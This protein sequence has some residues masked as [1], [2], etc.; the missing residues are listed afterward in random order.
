MQF[1]TRFSLALLVALVATPSAAHVGAPE[2]RGLFLDDDGSL[3]GA[4]TT[5]GVIEN[6][7]EG[8]VRTCEEA[9]GDTVHFYYWAKEREE[10]IVGTNGGILT[11]SDWGC[12]WDPSGLEDRAVTL[13]RTPRDQPGVLFASTSTTGDANGVFRSIDDGAT[14]AATSLSL[15]EFAFTSLQ[16]SVDGQLV[17]A[18]GIDYAVTLPRIFLSTDGGATFEEK[19]LFPEE[20]NV[21]F[22]NA[23]GITDDAIALATLRSGEQGSTLYLAS[24][25]LDVLGD[26]VAFDTDSANGVVTDYA[27]FDGTEYVLVN[28]SLMHKRAAGESAFV[29]DEDGPGRCLITPRESDRLWGCAQPFQ[30][31][32]FLY[33]E[34]A[35]DAWAPAIPHLE[36]EERRCPDGTIGEERCRYLFEPAFDGGPIGPEPGEPDVGPEGNE[37][38]ADPGPEEPEPPPPV[39]G[40]Q[41]SG[42]S[43]GAGTL[44][45]GLAVLVAL[46][47]RRR[48]VG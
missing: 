44:L 14:W 3:I 18:S 22:I 32:H 17:V 41:Q 39:C 33:V 2:G 16:V 37:P 4:G 38:E 7:A 30:L 34:E 26:G 11:S 13:L 46:R 20:S 1:Q 45:A 35:T 5:W 28:R 10:V 43:N 9:V 12:S 15:P 36:V 21:S 31:G 48:R 6:T 24:R 27:R 23:V 47:L 25:D 42:G 40:C 29:F 19:E 8:F